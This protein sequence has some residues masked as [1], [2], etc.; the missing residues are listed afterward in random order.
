[1]AKKIKIIGGGFSGLVSAFYLVKYGLTDITIYEKK[2]RLGG[3]IS[4][5]STEFGL[6]ESAAN[7]IL[8]CEELFEICSDI[9]LKTVEPKKETKKRFIFFKKP[10][11]WPFSLFQ[12][13]VL[14]PKILYFLV[15]KNKL[16]PK[17]G[18]SVF[19]WVNDIFGEALALNLA[20]P[21]L[22]GV[23]AAP[24]KMLSAS[25]VLKSI[26]NNSKKKKNK[27]QS[28]SFENGMGEFISAVENYL[29]QKG[30]KFKLNHSEEVIK[31]KG[32]I[33][34]FATPVNVTAKLIKK[35]STKVSESLSKIKMIDLHTATL[36]FKKSV[37]DLQG[38][39]CLFPRSQNFNSLGVLF[40]NCI[41]KN[42]S[43][44][45]SETFIFSSTQSLKC[46][47]LQKPDF[48]KIILEDRKRLF[49]N[50]EARPLSMELYKWSKA[51]PLYN[52]ELERVLEGLE[53]PSNIFLVG[54]YIE[55][56]G[57]SKILKYSKKIA[58]IISE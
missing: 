40:N 15:N 50:Q 54:N 31:E 35:Y 24:T 44:I 9:G 39:G 48:E 29:I 53:I 32:E 10:R 36:F 58:K 55:G 27:L 30:V 2:D 5:K 1:M 17:P 46:D 18:Q 38:F 6:V 56:L 57:L 20:E 47:D 26:F 41:F 52:V 14:M 22:Q 12:T 34:I 51:I 33:L 49:I 3:L 21:A 28:I 16:K 7:A 45:R 19:D 4:T 11:R 42:R 13:I 43:E 37:S 8:S 23:Y 25:L